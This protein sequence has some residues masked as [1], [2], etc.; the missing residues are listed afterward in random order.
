MSQA[1]VIEELP[2]SADKAWALMEDFGDMSAWA[3]G[4]RVRSV[5]GTGKGAVRVVDT[6]HGVYRER[7]EAHDPDS[8]SFQYSLLESPMKFEKYLAEVTFSDIDD[9]RCRIEWK[10]DFETQSLPEAEVIKL[11]ENLYRKGFI[12]ALRKTLESRT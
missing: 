7:C 1:C 5:E 8:R 10:S 11:T 12:A 9:D 4:A 6:D 3:P 2:A